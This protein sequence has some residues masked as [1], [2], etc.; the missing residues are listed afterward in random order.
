[1]ASRLSNVVRRERTRAELRL[2]RSAIETWLTRRRLADRDAAGTYVGRH[3]TQLDTI[4]HVLGAA[5]SQLADDADHLDT[6]LP[7]GEFYEKCRTLDIATVWL[8]RMWEFYR[9][10]FDQRDDD[11]VG[12][13]LRAADEVV[14]SCYH[15]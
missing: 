11:R 1:M 15:G 4:E 3:K 2:L 10:K 8:Q 12:A 7:E 9:Q 5:A 6:S 13:V 14:W